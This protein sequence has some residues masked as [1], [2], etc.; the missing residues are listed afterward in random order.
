MRT[1]IIMMMLLT[2]C[3]LFESHQSTGTGLYNSDLA[4]HL[5]EV[6]KR[7]D[8]PMGGFPLDTNREVLEA[9]EKAVRE[10]IYLTGYS[11]ERAVEVVVS[12]FKYSLDNER[13]HELAERFIRYHNKRDPRS[14]R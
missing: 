4:Q 7:G 13:A 6:R 10:Y 8:D 9:M 14:Y 12:N 11:R 5:H 3:G 2:G 1:M